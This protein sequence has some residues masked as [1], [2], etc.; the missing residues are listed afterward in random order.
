M[1][2]WA[3]RASVVLAVLA[4]CSVTDAAV[5]FDS[6]TFGGLKAR[7]IGPAV[8][9]GRIAALDAVW[10]DDK[11]TVYVGAATGGLWKS[12]DGATTFEPIFDDYT[13][14][15]GAVTIDPSDPNTV[16]VGTGETW[17][18][19]SV[20]IG[21]GVFKTTD[22]GKSWNNVGL[23]D[24]ERIVK[25]LVH[26]SEPD[27]VYVCATGHL[28]DA[29]E[30][31]GVYK[32]TDGGE[33]WEQILAID[34]DTG[35]GDLAM[36]EQEPDILYAG[37]WQFRRE[38]WFFT[39]GGPGSGLHRSTDGGES[40]ERIAAG[41]PE[42]ELGRIAIGVAPSRPNVVYA[43]VEAKDTG[44]FRSDDLGK[45]WT[46]M[47]HSSAV[48]GRPFYFSLIVV[49]PSDH[50]RVY[51]PGTTMALTT[52]GGENFSTIAGQTHSDHH[53]LWI[54]PRNVQ[55]LLLGTDGG[56]YESNDRGGSWTYR[57]SI[58][59]SQ[60]YQVSYDMEQ[61]YNVYGGL[62]DNGVWVGP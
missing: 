45:S 2:R 57:N 3:A 62:Q 48:E 9:G 7:S 44:F 56:L 17:T 16:W 58:P 40:W 53:A 8:M 49:D 36:D 20:S 46:R 4:V 5:K 34:A 50:D 25:I 38:P 51:K 32:T 31:R 47:A 33:S 60:F 28:W 37:M 55:H 1:R 52:D 35:C 26:P 23:T 59:I 19:N 30:E 11:L 10:I 42:G 6:N 12:D 13:M 43:T 24:S 27:T 39:S 41:L 61:P 21:E 15:I 29:N 54:D 22:G 14:S 18:R